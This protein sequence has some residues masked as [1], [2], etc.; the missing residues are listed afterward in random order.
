MKGKQILLKL[1]ALV[2]IAA[3]LSTGTLFGTDG[4]LAGGSVSGDISVTELQTNTI[5][6]GDTTVTIDYDIQSQSIVSEKDEITE[7]YKYSLKFIGAGGILELYSPSGVA[8]SVKSISFENCRIL[9]PAGAKVINGKI[10]N[11]SGYPSQRVIIGP[12]TYHTIDVVKGYAYDYDSGSDEPIYFAAA[13]TKVGFEGGSSPEGQY[14]SGYSCTPSSLSLHVSYDFNWFIMG[15]DDVTITAQYSPQVPGTMDIRSGKFTFS[16][17]DD[18]YKYQALSIAAGTGSMHLIDHV[19]GGL[20]LDLDGTAD[21]EQ[22]SSDT[23]V[24]LSTSSIPIAIDISVP[25]VTKYNP[26]TVRFGDPKVTFDLNGGSGAMDPE[27]V[28]SLEWKY[29]LPECK[30]TPPTGMEFDKWDKGAPG[31][32]LTVKENLT[33]KALWKDKPAAPQ[34]QEPEQEPQ[35]PAEQQEQQSDEQVTLKKLKSV[36]LKAVSKKKI[37]VSWKKLSKKLRK[38]VKKIQIQVSTDPEFK[39]ILKEKYLSSKKTSYT[40]GGL[41][42][43]TK[44]YIRIRAYTEKDGVKHVSEWVRKGKKTKKK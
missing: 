39:T 23:L 37:K 2:V 21:I 10:C 9:Y 42:K 4:A 44:Y 11:A 40:V 14:I 7:E 19:S 26:L 41:K 33:V 16:S 29:K 24:A 25:K 38:E 32:E 22:T 13:G 20:D 12:D 8:V 35:Q 31:T 3:L 36:K 15:T 34:E 18:R 30:A 17:D 6:E 28:T 27:S 5:L 43:N 1:T